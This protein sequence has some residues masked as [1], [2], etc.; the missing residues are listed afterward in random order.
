MDVLSLILGDYPGS[1]AV[2]LYAGHVRRRYG[3]R[4]E[5]PCPNFS[6]Y[7]R[8]HSA[9]VDDRVSTMEVG[10]ITGKSLSSWTRPSKQ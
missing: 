6:N 3:I 9:L 7:P 4:R 10:E 2:L 1:F 5:L 8:T